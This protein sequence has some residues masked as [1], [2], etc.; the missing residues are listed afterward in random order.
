MTR[1]TCAK[2]YD[3]MDFRLKQASPEKLR[4][5][6]RTMRFAMLHKIIQDVGYVGAH[7]EA[8]RDGGD[9][10]RIYPTSTETRTLDTPCLERSEPLT[11][12]ES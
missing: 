4:D 5:H 6:N 8:N 12:Y 11:V 7:G 2:A 3:A 1:T 9:R 10:R